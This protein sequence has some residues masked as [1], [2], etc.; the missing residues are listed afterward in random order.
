M[1]NLL[2][3]QVCFILKHTSPPLAPPHPPPPLFT[4]PKSCTL[5]LAFLVVKF[6]PRVFGVSPT[7]LSSGS[8]CLRHAMTCGAIPSP[9]P[10]HPKQYH[11]HATCMNTTHPLCVCVFL[12][13]I[14]P[15][16]G[17]RYVR[18]R[19]F[20]VSEPRETHPR[21]E[22]ADVPTPPCPPLDNLGCPDRHPPP[23]CVC[24]FVLSNRYWEI[25]MYGPGASS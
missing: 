24:C 13:F 8:C 10:R 9:L 5:F 6:H 1:V 7:F 19:G 17:N 16:L 15:I 22:I 12:C 25:V 21:S 20:I 18:S 3:F 4:H 14:K 23:V 11:K 2:L